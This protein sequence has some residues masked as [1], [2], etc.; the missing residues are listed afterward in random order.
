MGREPA[1][2]EEKVPTAQTIRFILSLVALVA[3][4]VLGAILA[5][6]PKPGSHGCDRRG[7]CWYVPR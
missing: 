2:P 4:L 3:A 6:P 7:S 1:G 5:P